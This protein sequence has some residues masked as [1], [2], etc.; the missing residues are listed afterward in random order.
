M[1]LD[2]S[3]GVKIISS[4]QDLRLIRFVKVLLDLV[5]GLHIIST[6]ILALV[7]VF[8]PLLLRNDIPLTASVPVAIGAGDE[9]QFGVQVADSAAQEIRAAFVNQAQGTLR[10]ETNNWGLVITSYLY[11]LLALIGL[12]YLFGLL[13]SVIQAIRQGNTFTQENVQNIRRIGYV[14]L[15]V[16]IIL[17]IVQYFASWMI[18]RQLE[19]VTPTLNLPSPFQVELIFISLLVLILAQVWSYGLELERDRALTI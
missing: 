17:P 10:L 15:L 14:M 7:M 18:L 9:P 6:I 8:S 2:N 12:A 3:I 11:Q 16:G 4:Q 1:N 5:Y 19:I 13:R